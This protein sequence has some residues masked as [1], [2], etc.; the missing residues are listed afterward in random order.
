M[1]QAAR[2]RFTFAEYV[3]IEEDSGIKLEF[4][5]G[6]V[7]AM[8]G[9]TPEHAGLTANVLRLLGNAL[10]DRPCRVFSP[11]LRVR[12]RATGLGTYPDVTVICGK[13]E[14]DPEDPKRHTV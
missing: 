7:F 5:D 13:L 14:L 3:S 12:V 10:Q 8:S 4:V 1:G 11:D 9:G 2:H 6:G